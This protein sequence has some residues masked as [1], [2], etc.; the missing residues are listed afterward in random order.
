MDPLQVKVPN[1]S[2]TGFTIRPTRA[3]PDLIRRSFA[4]AR[5]RGIERIWI[6]QECIHQ[7]DPEDKR[8]LLGVM[9]LLYRHADVTLGVLGRKIQC[10]KDVDAIE[11]LMNWGPGIDDLCYRIFQD[12]WFHRAWTSQESINA[13]PSNMVYL[14]GWARG[15]DPTGEQWED[16]ASVFEGQKIQHELELGGHHLGSMS[17]HGGNQPARMTESLLTLNH[18]KEG[19]TLSSGKLDEMSWWI[20]N[21]ITEPPISTLPDL[22]RLNL[23]RQ[24][25]KWNPRADH[26]AMSIINAYMTLNSRA[27]LFRGDRLSIYANLARYEYHLDMEKI[28]GQNPDISFSACLMALALSNGDQ[29][30]L[31]DSTFSQDEEPGRVISQER[32]SWLPHGEATLSFV[33]APPIMP[34]FTLSGEYVST[35]FRSFVVSGKLFMQGLLWDIRPF[36]GLVPL[37]GSV[38][39]LISLVYD[40]NVNSNQATF[41]AF[42][43]VVHQLFKCGRLGLS[44]LE[45]IL[46]AGAPSSLKSPSSL[47]QLIEELKS[48]YR[49]GSRW[50]T[51]FPPFDG[52]TE[53][54]LEGW[55]DAPLLPPSSR[56]DY[57][58]GD[59]PRWISPP[60]QG[61]SMVPA[62]C[63]T[64]IM[65]WIFFTI[66]AG[67]DL[68]IGKCSTPAGEMHGIFKVDGSSTRQVFVPLT[69][70]NYVFGLDSMNVK[71]LKETMWVVDETS[72]VSNEIL[73]L[74][75]EKVGFSSEEKAAMNPRALRAQQTRDA[76]GFWSPFLS[77]KGVLQSKPWRLTPLGTG[78]LSSD[79]AIFKLTI[80]ISGRLPLH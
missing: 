64:G 62:F 39:K 14:V 21:Q 79:S 55:Q 11:S 50:P 7:D 66:A 35:G 3:S 19:F 60:Q 26:H 74:A 25:L 65:E 51:H 44:L 13:G 34:G 47:S 41:E 68:P 43:L 36:R 73:S 57:I 59:R 2:S 33:L 54:S 76:C 58:S 52:R 30:L 78:T 48:C 63:A 56:P 49:N 53:D 71:S 4:F 22:N 46:T 37:Q 80:R 42:A 6:D 10:R 24:E 27:N 77:S 29:T 61:G 1:K 45:I 16:M 72:V 38:R 9:H 20:D 28:T 8:A 69:E 70:L 12:R 15:F 17:F 67:A 32:P 75:K 31:L 23:H 18:G 40:E 5:S